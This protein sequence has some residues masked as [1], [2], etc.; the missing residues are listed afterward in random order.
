MKRVSVIA[1][2][3]RTDSC[4]RATRQGN[5]RALRCCEKPANPARADATTIR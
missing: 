1:V 4:S 3:R 2:N 5:I